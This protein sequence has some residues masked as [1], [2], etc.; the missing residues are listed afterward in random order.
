M[1]KIVMLVI[2]FLLVVAYCSTIKTSRINATNKDE[3]KEI[4]FETN[5]VYLYLKENYEYILADDE[6][7]TL[8]MTQEQIEKVDKVLGMELT[9][10]DENDIEKLADLKVLSTF[11]NLRIYGTSFCSI[12]DKNIN[13]LKYFNDLSDL[14]LE[15]LKFNTDISCITKFT[16]LKNLR[17]IGYTEEDSCELGYGLLDISP[18]KELKNLERLDLSIGTL[19]SDYLENI[20]EIISNNKKLEKLKIRLYSVDKKVKLPD[21]FKNQNDMEFFNEDQKKVEFDEDG[22]I[23]LKKNVDKFSKEYCTIKYSN[24]GIDD[25]ELSI[26]W[27]SQEE[28]DSLF[29]E[30]DIGSENKYYD[31]NKDNNISKIYK[32]VIP[33]ASIVMLAGIGLIIVKKYKSKNSL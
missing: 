19:N 9:D 6:N 15:R 17:L 13:D 18:L 28:F 14:T 23:I 29:E 12:F 32:I 33:V 3:V 24:T 21:I 10:S 30:Y 11:P 27:I 5:I 26:Y 20:K 25:C 1:K 2:S 16:N 4:K 31:T 22:N 7:L 8:K